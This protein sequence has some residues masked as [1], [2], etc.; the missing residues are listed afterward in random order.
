M[1]KVSHL[2]P[3][4]LQRRGLSD[5][6][7][8]SYVVFLANEWIEEHLPQCCDHANVASYSAGAVHIEVDTP[9]MAEELSMVTKV[10]LQSL[11]RY[12]GIYVQEIRV[13]LQNMVARG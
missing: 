2:I 4:V 12:E 11:N 6:A 8:A 10:L 5:D 7:N 9:A 1:D 3:K 13:I